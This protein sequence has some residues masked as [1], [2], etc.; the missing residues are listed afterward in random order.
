MLIAFG[1]V[2]FA[3]LGIGLSGLVRSAE[4]SSA[5]VNLIVLPMAFLTGAFGPTQFMPVPLSFDAVE[6]TGLSDITPRFS[7]AYDLT[8]RQA[9]LEFE[10][11]ETE[12]EE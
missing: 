1:V 9:D 8:G 10:I 11:V 7:F 3:A 5:V 12:V 6:T 2:C 4:G